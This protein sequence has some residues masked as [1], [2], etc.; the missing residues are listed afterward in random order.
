MLIIKEKQARRLHGIKIHQNDLAIYHLMCR[1]DR[2]EWEIV[3]D[4][5]TKYCYWTYQELN[6]DK[7]NIF[8]SKNTNHSER[9][10][11][12]CTL[13][14]KEMGHNIVYLGNSLVLGKNKSK[15]VGRLKER[16]KTRL[17]WWNGQLL[18]KAG[19][20]TVIKSMS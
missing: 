18:S 19:K 9:K 3:N 16:L 15:E 11:I 20:A 6:F 8:F 17:Q 7:S 5:L 1:A 12:T 14:F 2:R 4:Y 13:G 10:A